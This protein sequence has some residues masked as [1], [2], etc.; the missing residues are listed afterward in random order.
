MLGNFGVGG[1]NSM[2]KNEMGEHMT[3]NGE[4]RGAYKDV[5]KNLKERDHLQTLETDGRIIL[6]YSCKK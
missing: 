4:R 1:G 6:K 5:R 3:R 2:K